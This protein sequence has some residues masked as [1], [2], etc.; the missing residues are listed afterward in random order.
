MLNFL[1]PLEKEIFY[2]EKK[3]KTILIL[4]IM[5][6]LFL[7]ALS[8]IL[9]SINIYISGQVKVQKI[10]YE[11]ASQQLNFTKTEALENKIKEVNKDFN[12]F[13]SFYNNNPNI[14]SQMEK[15][16]EIMPQSIHLTNITF[17][18]NTPSKKPSSNNKEVKE[19]QY[20]F[21]VF[22]SGSAP[23]NDRELA[24]F[25]QAIEDKEEFIL[26]SFPISNWGKPSFELSFKI[27]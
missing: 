3:K 5:S 14:I 1:P 13:Y 22:L 9:F 24:E 11:D 18:T 4:G 7:I 23:S 26:D 2:K 12:L 6:V 27:K 15:I 19:D 21:M 17:K 16:S 25:K 8:L 10:I 20:K